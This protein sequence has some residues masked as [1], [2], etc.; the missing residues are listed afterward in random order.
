MTTI[1]IENT[2]EQ[3]GTAS[4][5]VDTLNCVMTSEALTSDSGAIWYKFT[6]MH[7]YIM[8]STI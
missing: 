6:F 1:K 5:N 7:I 8:S 2:W 3:I 4:L